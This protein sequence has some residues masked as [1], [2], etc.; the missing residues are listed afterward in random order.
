MMVP[1]PVVSADLTIVEEDVPSQ[2][3]EVRPKGWTLKKLKPVHKD[4]CS[5][6]AQGMKLVEAAAICGVTKQY[7]WMLMQQPLCRAYIE[8]MNTVTEARL[9]AMFSQTADVIQDGLNGT[10]SETQL[11]AARLHMET[12]GRIGSRGKAPEQSGQ[13]DRLLQLSE[14][15]VGLL[16]TQRGRSNEP[17]EDGEFQQSSVGSTF[18][19]G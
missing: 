12:I 7:V 9:E 2:P 11:K 17:I 1:D 19:S 10:A 15:L 13:E 16:T 3:D 8:Q 6:V 18:P 5:Y 4:I 14:R